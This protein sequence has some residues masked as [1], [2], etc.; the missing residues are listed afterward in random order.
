MFVTA[1]MD[2]KQTMTILYKGKSQPYTVS[3]KQVKQSEIVASKNVNLIDQKLSSS[4]KPTPDH[5]WRAG[6]ATPLSRKK[7]EIG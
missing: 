3:H 4:N 5:P 1:C 7:I 6:F 2:A